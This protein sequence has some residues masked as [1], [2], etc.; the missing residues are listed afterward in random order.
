MA[1]LTLYFN[2]VLVSSYS[3]STTNQK[4][5]IKEER[6]EYRQ[7]HQNHR[8]ASSSYCSMACGK[9][10]THQLTLTRSP[11][12]EFC[13]LGSWSLNWIVTLTT[14]MYCR[15]T[16]RECLVY[17]PFGKVGIWTI[18]AGL[19]SRCSTNVWSTYHAKAEE[20]QFVVTRPHALL[21]RYKRIPS[22]GLNL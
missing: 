22:F 18:Q 6:L 14:V 17:T 11:V 1:S 19:Q 20:Q 2:E 16:V 21:L 12:V 10:K 3:V 8:S 5:F 9:T 4:S 13:I 15:L 7:V